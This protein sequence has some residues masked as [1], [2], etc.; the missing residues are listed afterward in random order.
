MD[1]DVVVF[2]TAPTGHTL[3]LLQFPT[4]IEKAFGKLL[5]LQSSLGPMMSQ[6][7]TSLGHTTHYPSQTTVA[8]VDSVY[9]IR[10]F[11]HFL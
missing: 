3:R 1:F 2:D 4:I 7:T 10:L 5:S 8:N 9:L 6:V 11:S